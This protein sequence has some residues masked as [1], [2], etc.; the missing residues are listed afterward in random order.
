MTAPWKPQVYLVGAGPGDA[1]LLTRRGE[2]LLKRADIVFYDALIDRGLLDLIPPGTARVGVGKRAGGI[3][4]KQSEIQEQLIRAAREGRTVVRLKGGDPFVFGRGGEEIMALAAAGIRF[5][6]VPGVSSASAVPAMIGMPLTVRGLSSVVHIVTGHIDPADAEGPVNWDLL[7]QAGHTVVVLMGSAHLI[8]ILRRLNASGLEPETPLAVIQWGT[9]PRQ[10]SL[11][12]TLGEALADP[13]RFTL[14]SPALAV[15]GGVAGMDEGLNWFEQRPL[16]GRRMV[17]TRPGGEE[18]DMLQAL[19][20]AGADA[21]NIPLIRFDP[22][23]RD[24][25][26]ALVDSIEALREAE[27][28]LILPSGAA[29]RFMFRAL[30]RLQLDARAMA[31]I[32]VA[33]LSEKGREQLA[34]HGLR[35][36]F[37][38]DRAMGAQLA[39]QLP[40]DSGCGLVT[41][42]GSRF[43][44]PE[45][46]ETLERRGV[47]TTLLSLYGTRP[48]E[49]GAAELAERVETGEVDDVI[50]TSPSGVE[51]LRT[52]LRGRPP[53]ARVRCWAIG[54]TTAEAMRQAGW[55][56]AGSAGSATP[57]SLVDLLIGATPAAKSS[58]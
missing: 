36:D 28:W 17:L 16:F 38:P 2:N 29:I 19:L 31:G 35:A 34:A 24:S 18:G 57:E 50:L 44:R 54:P 48:E 11:R 14:A 45:L 43:S 4:P 53:T 23:D 6:V 32:R 13:G 22:E 12:G 10:R 33:V 15:I 58:R 40:L 27:G 30:G 26:E 46:R 41:V 5:E 49:Q 37:V 51:A 47:R 52:T 25:D 8:E 20:E 9:L 55:E 56:V 39:G 42:A 1:G 3:G 21:V 7:T